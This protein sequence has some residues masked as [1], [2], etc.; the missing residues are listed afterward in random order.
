MDYIATGIKPLDEIL[1]GGLRKGSLNVIAARPAMGKTALALQIAAG[2]AERTD[3]EVLIFSPSLT[4]DG[5]V[6]RITSQLT[7]IDGYRIE[8]GRLNDAEQ[9]VLEEAKNRLDK[10][11]FT[12]VCS[13]EITAETICRRIE[14][15]PDPAAVV[16][17]PAD[18]VFGE[19]DGFAE[20]ELLRSAA[21][22]AGVPVVF[23]CKIPR[24]VEGR[25]DKR[26][27]ISD[28]FPSCL[29]A[30]DV[31]VFPYRESY[32]DGSRR[33]GAAEVRVVLKDG[34]THAFKAVFDSAA[35]NFDADGRE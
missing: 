24:A 31:A 21:L 7:G 25:K 8:H 35:V 17:D 9:N 16:V 28:L 13:P 27:K 6:K 19:R 18:A 12:L 4:A 10:M 32:Y 14:E 20:T 30:A 3:R 15:T 11:K 22:R 2:I 34:E 23:C 1:E 29:R 26:P 33:D 5:F